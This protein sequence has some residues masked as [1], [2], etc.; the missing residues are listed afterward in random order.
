MYVILLVAARKGCGGVQFWTR[1]LF[2]LLRH[3]FAE[4]YLQRISW[5]YMARLFISQDSFDQWCSDNNAAL[6]GETLSFDGH[7]LAITPGVYFATVA[8]GDPD[9]LD[10]LGKVKNEE[11]LATMSAEQYH[12]SVICGDVAYDV[13]C[14]FVGVLTGG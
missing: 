14:G 1:P 11:E 2:T 4:G 7:R 3:L 13:V 10:L 6:D 5:S 8:G 12:N 9:S